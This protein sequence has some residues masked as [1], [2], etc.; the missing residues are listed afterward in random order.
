MEPYL[1]RGYQFT[2]SIGVSSDA[3]SAPRTYCTIIAVTCCYDNTAQS[4]VIQLP[5]Y[6]DLT[7]HVE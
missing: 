2:Y 5:P 1:V 6:L 3:D 4:E 7:Q